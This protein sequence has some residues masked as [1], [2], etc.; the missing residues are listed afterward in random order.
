MPRSP[1]TLCN[2]KQPTAQSLHTT[3]RTVRPRGQLTGATFDTAHETCPTLL[4][5]FRPGATHSMGKVRLT[6]SPARATHIALDT[7]STDE[8]VRACTLTALAVAPEIR[9]KCFLIFELTKFTDTHHAQAAFN[10]IYETVLAV[11][12]ERAGEEDVDI[13]LHVIATV[14]DTGR[15]VVQST[16]ARRVD[17]SYSSYAIFRVH[18]PNCKAFGEVLIVPRKM[19]MFD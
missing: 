1:S 6:E 10:T 18:R 7:N 15:F 17:D 3:K 13:P 5:Q 14:S 2:S 12:T 4:F 11:L 8:E 19:E 16:I 9:N